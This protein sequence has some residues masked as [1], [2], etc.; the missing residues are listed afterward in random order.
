MQSELLK[1]QIPNV[2][3]PDGTWTEQRRNE[4]LDIMTKNVYGYRPPDPIELEFKEY[5][6]DECVFEEGT[7]DKTVYNYFKNR[8]SAVFKKVSVICRLSENDFPGLKT[9][10][11]LG[12]KFTFDVS[13]YIPKRA[14]GKKIP[15][16]AALHYREAFDSSNLPI[17][18]IVEKG[19]ALFAFRYRHLVNDY[20]ER[21][22]PERGHPQFN[23]T[24]LDRLYYGN[25][26]LRD[27]PAERKGDDPGTIAIWSWGAS[28]VMDYIQTQGAYIDL[29]K[30]AVSGHS[31]LGKTALFTS[32][33]DKRFTH[34]LSS[35]SC[36]GGAAL[37]H[38]CKKENLQYMSERF[39][40]WFCE[41][42]KKSY[43]SPLFD[44]HFL[45]ACIAPRKLYIANSDNDEYCDQDSEYLSCVAAS[46]AYEYIGMKGFVRPERLPETGDKFHEG[47]IAYHLR[48][49]VHAFQPDDWVM[50]LD[51]LN[52]A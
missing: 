30:V 11:E 49:G 7:Y 52:A 28:R 16:I 4:A 1:R 40:E 27:C 39:P 25:Y 20:P 3:T 17:V 31:R 46:A 48:P 41:N 43:N 42:L 19:V 33:C 38:G 8:D 21:N 14:A 26:R 18:D 9:M 23:N 13:C 29:N 32:A 24:G 10:P 47:D 35:A 50:M 36:A 34:V 15:A 2:L 22:D 12:D 5:R 44:M 45:L 37:S 51:F 6:F